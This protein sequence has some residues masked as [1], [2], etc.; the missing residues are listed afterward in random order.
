MRHAKSSWS[1]PD[2]ADFDRPLNDRGLRAA[3][4]MGLLFEA[5]GYI[6]D[7]LISSPARRAA[8]TAMLVNGSL[9]AEVEI[10]FDERVY[11]ASPQSLNQI[12]GKI[13]D[14]IGSV[15][16]VGHNPGMEGFTRFLTSRSEAMPTAALAV[17]DLAIE[18]WNEIALGR[19]TLI[20]VIRPRDHGST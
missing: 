7:L 4:L 11:E 9:S 1:E 8:E 2:L 6:P 16:V 5:R 14:Q 17:I 10:R 3:P 15:M 12:V 13:E 20:E 18:K 19:G